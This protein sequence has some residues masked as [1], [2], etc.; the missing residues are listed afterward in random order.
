MRRLWSSAAPLLG[1]L[2]A[3]VLVREGELRLEMCNVPRAFRGL[4]VTLIY[5]GLISLAFY[6]LVGHQLPT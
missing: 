6:G 2:L 1:N 4:P 5:I 3:M